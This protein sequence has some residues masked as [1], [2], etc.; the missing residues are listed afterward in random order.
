MLYGNS[1]DRNNG[2][3]KILV[4]KKENNKSISPNCMN[5][6]K[7][8]NV[9]YNKELLKNIKSKYIVNMIRK[10]IINF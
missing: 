1:I 6:N 3:M 10:Y 8:D 9:S 4:N 2:E 5:L 7:E